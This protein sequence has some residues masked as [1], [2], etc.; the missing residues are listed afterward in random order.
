M[1]FPGRE[2]T[3]ERQSCVPHMRRRDHTQTLPSFVYLEFCQIGF[4][5]PKAYKSRRLLD[6]LHMIIQKNDD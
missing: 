3:R 1:H 6:L 4:I 5:V 2:K